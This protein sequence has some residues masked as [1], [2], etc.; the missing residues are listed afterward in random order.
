[1]VKNLHMNMFKLVVWGMLILSQFLHCSA[2]AVKSQQINSGDELL[3]DS[4]PLQLMLVDCASCI[5][6]ILKIMK[7]LKKKSRNK[8]CLY[9]QPFQDVS[10]V[11]ALKTNSS[12]SS[13]CKERNCCL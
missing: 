12:D 2:L 3:C 13:I 11:K 4:V 5:Q 1:M 7:I 10:Y 8:I 9:K 6:S